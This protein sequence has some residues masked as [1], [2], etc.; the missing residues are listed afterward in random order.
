M[1]PTNQELLFPMSN[2]MFCKKLLGLID[3]TA[4]LSM[5][6]KIKGHPGESVLEAGLLCFYIYKCDSIH[7][8]LNH[9]KYLLHLDYTYIWIEFISCS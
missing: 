3:Q 8:R 5:G 7:F 1:T 2:C 9:S 4:C 6:V